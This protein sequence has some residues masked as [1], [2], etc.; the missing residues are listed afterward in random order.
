MV[1]MIIIIRHY[2]IK[3]VRLLLADKKVRKVENVDYA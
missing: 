3:R 1:D 2:P